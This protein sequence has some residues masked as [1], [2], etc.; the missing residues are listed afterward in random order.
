MI[1]RNRSEYLK[2][3]MQE[4]QYPAEA[5]DFLLDSYDKIWANDDAKLLFEQSIGIYEGRMMWS[6]EAIRGKMASVAESSG[7]HVYTVEFL[8]LLA[9]SEH[10]K[11][12]YIERGIDLSIYHDSCMDFKAKLFECKKNKDIW[13]TYVGSWFN[14]WF[15]LTRF[16]LGR[17]QFEIAYAY[18]TVEGTY[19]TVNLGQAV[20]NMHIPALGP[21]LYE[22]CRESFLR[23]YDFFKHLFPDNEVPFFCCSWIISPQHEFMLKPDSNLRQFMK[24]FK[25][26]ETE[27][28]VEKALNAYVFGPA[29]L[30]DVDALPENTSMQRAYKEVLKKGE[31]PC[32]GVGVFHIKDGKFI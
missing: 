32:Q 20:V 26:R 29:D 15:D 30:T 21:L 2:G 18:F 13:G 6:Y 1:V 5:I 11:E 8:M 7:V 31:M 14:R 25:I 9:M 28:S 19:K 12:L 24:F 27:T 16:A 10:M 4:F 17:L 3:F 22:D 23:A